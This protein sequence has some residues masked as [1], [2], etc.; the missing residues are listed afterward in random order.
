MKRFLALLLTL[1]CVMVLATTALADAKISVTDKKLITFEGDWSGYFFAK[2]ENTG[3]T[4]AYV[5]YDGTLVCFDSDDDIILTDNYISTCPSGI[6]L[7]PG[8]TAFIKNSI[9]ETEL[10]KSTVA[11]YKF[12]IK[13]DDY[14]YTYSAMNAEATISY[15]GA[16]SYDNYIYVTFT[17][18][19]EDVIY[20]LYAVAAMYD[21]NGALMFVDYEYTSTFGVHPGST[22]TAKVD[23][24]KDLVNYYTRESL[25]PTT[26]E[27]IVYVEKEN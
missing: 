23:I 26:V 12:S 27:A 4:G 10:K 22:I 14:G 18:T 8:E 20:G 19:T 25:T 13:A 1:C 7:E 5:G 3:D 11:D 21:Q 17:N 24:D 6:Y 15:E 9:L 2:V 16:D